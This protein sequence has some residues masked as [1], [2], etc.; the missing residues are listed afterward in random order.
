MLHVRYILVRRRQEDLV[1]TTGQSSAGKLLEPF[2]HQ[3]D[4]LRSGVLAGLGQSDT[5]TDSFA[6]QV[7]CSTCLVHL[8]RVLVV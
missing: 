3:R 1:A 2:Q 7:E 5:E 4:F 8:Q 6:G